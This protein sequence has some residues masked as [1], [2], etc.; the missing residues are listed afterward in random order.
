M[1]QLT[2]HPK[3][4]RRLLA[5][6]NVVP[7]ID[8]MLV[9]LVIFM[10]TAPLLTQGINV[11]LP[12]AAAKALSSKNQTPIIV[13]IDSAGHYYLNASQHPGRP[14]SP[15]NLMNQ[16]AAHLQIAEQA[17]QLLPVY[18]KGDRY[19]NYGKVVNAMVLLQEA[20]ANDVGL[21]TSPTPKQK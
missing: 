21:I 1:S 16:V 6:I 17:H 15:E 7:Y 9:L 13:S 20:G 11:N 14:I 4:R 19:V 12:Q 2:R 10:I 8:V 3:Q 18:V 5:E